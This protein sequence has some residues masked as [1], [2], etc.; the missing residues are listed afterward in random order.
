MIW[1]AK[2]T[3]ALVLYL[4]GGKREGTEG[5]FG[6][7]RQRPLVAARLLLLLLL[8]RQSVDSRQAQSV[9]VERDGRCASVVKAEERE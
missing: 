6:G 2:S 1:A 3:R 5:L 4:D 7:R 9:Y 8:H